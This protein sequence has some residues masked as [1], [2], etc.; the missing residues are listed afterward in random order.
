M[1]W[2]QVQQMDREG[3]QIGA[4]TQTHVDLGVVDGDEADC[5]IRGSRRDLE[6]QLGHD[7]TLFAYPYGRSTEHARGKS[8]PNQARGLS[9]LRLVSWRSGDVGR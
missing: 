7:V 8:R 4:H 1:T 3:F 6:E 9:L 2:D 5:E